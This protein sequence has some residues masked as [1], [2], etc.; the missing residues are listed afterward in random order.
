MELRCVV[1]ESARAASGLDDVPL[2]IRFRL[3]LDGRDVF[4]LC[5]QSPTL[6]LTHSRAIDVA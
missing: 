1:Q 3:G 2:Y 5:H 6:L 4:I